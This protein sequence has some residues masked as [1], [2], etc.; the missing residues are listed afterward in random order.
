MPYA[1]DSI[2]G[3]SVKLIRV[4]ARNPAFIT[5]IA[6]LYVGMSGA[7]LLYEQQKKTATELRNRTEELQRQVMLASAERSLFLEQREKNKD[8]QIFRRLSFREKHDPQ[9]QERL[10]AALS[11]NSFARYALQTSDLRKARESLD[12]SVATFPTLEAQYY[13]GVVD[14]LEG[15]TDDAIGAWTKLIKSEDF[16]DDLLMY[17]SL[18][19]Y[20]SG[21]LEAARKFAEQYSHAR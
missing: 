18:A 21:N 16:P 4:L 10:Q 1:A 15:R 11:L 20:R 13:L 14:Y 6:L 3:T 7:V 5:L 2:P 8:V 12:E 17:L 9:D 19:E